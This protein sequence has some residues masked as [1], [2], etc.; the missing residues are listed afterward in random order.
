MKAHGWLKEITVP[1]LGPRTT[2]ENDDNDQDEPDAIDFDYA[3]VDGADSQS[4]AAAD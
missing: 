3:D 4:S 1:N 2:T